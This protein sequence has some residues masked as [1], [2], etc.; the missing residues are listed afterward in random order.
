MRNGVRQGGVLSAILYCL[1]VDN[2]FKELRKSGYG[3][4][5]N[6]NFHGILGY[7]DDNMLIAP[8]QY[9]LQAMLKICEKYA[10]DHNLKSSTDANPVKCK[11]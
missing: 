7:S 8:S 6:G 1:Y 5:V 3:C 2:L 9:A 10:A 11:T 4:W